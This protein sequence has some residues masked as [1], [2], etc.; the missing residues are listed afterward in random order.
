M[1]FQSIKFIAGAAI[2][3][4][5]LFFAGS[6]K[7]ATLSVSLTPSPAS[8][9]APLNGVA[10]T[11]NVSGTAIDTSNYTFYCNRSDTGTNITAG[12]AYKLDGTNSNPLS[13][14]A[15]VC[16]SVYST[17]GTY[18]AKVIVER[19]AVA[20]EAR[21]V[22]TVNNPSPPITTLK[23]RFLLAPDPPVFVN[24]PISVTWGSNIELSWSATNGA[25]GCT[26]SLTS[27]GG[28]SI[29]ESGPGSKWAGAKPP[30]GIWSPLTKINVSPG[31]VFSLYCTNIGGNGPTAS[32]E[33]RPLYAGL[34]A[35]P[36]LNNFSLTANVGG[37]TSGTFRYFFDCTNDG[38]NELDTGNIASNSYTASNFCGYPLVGTYTPKVTVWHNYATAV[39]KTTVT[40]TNPSQTLTVAKAG[41][42]TGTVTNAPAGINCGSTCSAS[43]I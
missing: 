21:V 18:T 33:A 5:F 34:L 32:F 7:A 26:G 8:G 3:F 36:S 27:A 40:V 30:S 10:L 31:M 1:K 23:G 16:N 24:G 19:A 9:T 15:G 13:A 25:T 28:G 38:I 39:G 14:P 17:A 42:G 22:I 37:Y 43:Y 12:Y 6:A 2:V 4:L 29:I 11:A 20:A 35:T 41:T